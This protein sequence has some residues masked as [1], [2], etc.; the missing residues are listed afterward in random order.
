[1][2]STTQDSRTAK[3]LRMLLT[4][5]TAYVAL[6]VAALFAVTFPGS[7]TPL[8]PFVVAAV[9]LV[10]LAAYWPFRGTMLD[11]V[12]TV[13]FGALSL[14]FT[15]FPFP[16]GEVPPQLAN[17]QNLY[18]WALSAGFL[19]VALVVFSFG[20]QM[21]RANRTHLIRAL[22]HAV[23]SGVAAISV[24]GW[25]FLPELGE[26]V[27][28]GTTA[29]IVTIVILVALAAAL[30]AASVLWVRDADPDPEIR[31]P[32]AGTGVLTTMLMGAPVAAATLLLAGMIN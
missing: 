7:S 22:S 11:R 32:W 26:L 25:C 23:T 19:L 6:I 8:V 5:F 12:V 29:G 4:Q 31:Q 10:L 9:I 14:A 24:A 30:A 18:S 21:A 27:T 17:E 1:M 15:L 20:R 16:A 28:R 13:V 2:T 3:T